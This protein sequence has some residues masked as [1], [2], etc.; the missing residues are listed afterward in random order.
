MRSC[1][2]NP[3]VDE[4][5]PIRVYYKRCWEDIEAADDNNKLVCVLE[6]LRSSIQWE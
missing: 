4:D 5:Y 2:E 1:Y 6:D 3:R